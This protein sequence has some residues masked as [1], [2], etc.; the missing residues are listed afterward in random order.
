MN[1]TY[2]DKGDVLT[3]TVPDSFDSRLIRDY[4]KSGLKLSSTIVSRV[5]FGGVFLNEKEVHMRAVVRAGDRVT[6][7][8]PMEKSE[9]IEPMQIPLN[10]LFEDEYILAVNKPRSMP[11]H[12]S[13]GNHLPTL[14]NAVTAYYNDRPFVFRAVNRLDRDTS[15]IVII[16]KNAYAAAR[17]SDDMKHGE[18]EKYY[19][20]LLS[21]A[22]LEHS[23][24]I[25]APIERESEESMRRIVRPD[26]KP[27]RTAYEITEILPDGR[28]VAS[29]RLFTGRTHQ[30]R[31][32]MA[33]VGA[34]LYG[35]FLYGERTEDGYLLHCSK[36]KLPHPVSGEIIEI[37]APK[38]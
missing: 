27:A 22:P 30:I 21:R 12:P 6:V 5:K 4:L 17:L 2:T 37:S 33:H 26:G 11:V 38:I 31:V 15:G 3:A 10:V 13:R 23:A 34:P 16:A 36:I 24:V 1:L 35:D 8:F 7:I 20:A 32:H 29:I 9:G 19:T 18:F 25:D 14:A 28:A